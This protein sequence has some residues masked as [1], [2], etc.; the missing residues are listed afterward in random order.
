MASFFSH[1]CW[2]LACCVGL[3]CAAVMARADIAINLDNDQSRLEVKAIVIATGGEGELKANRL[4]DLT[5]LASSERRKYPATISIDELH[6]IADVLT[7]A[8]RA[9]GYTFDSLYL[10]PQTVANG[11]VQFRYQKSV[12]VSINVIN[13]T[14]YEIGRAHV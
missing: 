10:P 11:I 14:D 7:V 13:N 1:R 2:Q 8:V 5:R 9:E 6:R 3:L 4:R 12:L